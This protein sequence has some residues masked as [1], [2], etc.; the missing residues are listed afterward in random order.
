MKRNNLLLIWGIIA[1]IFVVECIYLKTL[2]YSFVR[3]FRTGDQR[4]FN[5]PPGEMMTITL[6]DSTFDYRVPHRV[7]ENIFGEVMY[8]LDST[9]GKDVDSLVEVANWVRGKLSFGPASIDN[10]FPVEA[11]LSMPEKKNVTFLCDSYTRLFVIACQTLGIPAR[12]V[13]LEGHVVAEAFSRERDRW[14][15]LDPTYGY[16]LVLND[17]PLSVVG[18][19]NCYREN[20]PMTPVVFGVEGNDG[21]YGP[22][23]EIS[24]KK[25]YLNGMTMVSDQT[26]NR[27][28]IWNTFLEKFSLPIAKIQYLNGTTTLIGLREERLRVVIV[29]TACILVLL[30][31]LLIRK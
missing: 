21:L 29:V 15:M 31:I 10:T 11:L 20:L 14:I 6:D 22:E 28:K 13:E 25:I 27:K 5:M 2:P 18:I 3:V 12:I 9:G 16:Y 4:T 26:V 1:V 30:T 17:M 24:L 7:A 19:I 8:L 23:Q